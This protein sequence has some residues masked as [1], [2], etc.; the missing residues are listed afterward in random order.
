M[1]V[2]DPHAI[3]ADSG[4]GKFRLLHPAR[5]KLTVQDHLDDGRPPDN[6]GGERGADGG[7][8]DNGGNAGDR[9]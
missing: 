6:H 8:R 4:N 5:G 9:A 7:E 3:E 1:D 2:L